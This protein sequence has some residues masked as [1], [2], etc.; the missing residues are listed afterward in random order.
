MLLFGICYSFLLIVAGMVPDPRLRYGGP[1]I[2]LL[3]AVA[4]GW[5]SWTFA[6]WALG[7]VALTA[8]MREHAGP[9]WLRWSRYGLWFLVSI[10]LATHSLPGYQGLQLV[11]GVV[12]KEGSVPASL[13]FNHDKVLVAWSLLN[14]VPLVAPSIRPVL[15]PGW[16]TPWLIGAGLCGVMASALGLGLVEWRPGLTSW[17][18][19]FA[20]GNLL[21]TCVVEELLFRGVVQRQLGEWL[22][23]WSALMVASA[24]F[25]VA[26]MAGGW[27]YV[28]VATLAGLLFG[29]TYLVTGRLVWAVLC[30][31]A[32]NL[33]HFTLFTYPM[34]A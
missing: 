14:W 16:T 24:V 11:N 30:H 18:W 1:V 12:L 25:G 32:V 34:S 3:L 17:F 26:H 6:G 9:R 21:N 15:R 27:S 8:W 5:I 13:W 19:L 7:Y 20:A 23:P 2:L 22:S 28:A 29:L 10:G 31:W 33:V 4:V